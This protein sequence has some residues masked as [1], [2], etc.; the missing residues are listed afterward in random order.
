MAMEH[1]GTVI[2][3]DA[4][5]I[6]SD[7]PI[8]SAQPGPEDQDLVPHRLYGVLD[9]ADPCSAA[10]W[11]EMARAEIDRCWSEGRLPILVGGTGLYLKALI[12]GLAPVPPVD[13]AVRA[14]IRAMPPA[15]VRQA[16]EAED[17]ALAARLNVNDRQRNARALEVIRSTGKSLLHWQQQT[18][19][20]IGDR[21]E[22]AAWLVLPAREQL[23]RSCDLRFDR[24]IAAGALEEV[25]R[26]RKRQLSPELP[27]MKAL[28]VPP[29]IAHLEGLLTLDE[30]IFRSKLQT[31]QYAKRQRTWF[32]SGGQSRGWLSSA[33]SLEG[34]S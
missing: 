26:L 7:L 30:A 2:N 32:A 10:R 18:E 28:G 14:A 9:G 33:G 6:Y 1:G 22:L 16:L 4:S 20:G 21:V 5:Q 11:V 8:L 24:M 31:R 15:D 17:P 27:V 25:G 3:A 13:E 19:G 34:R 23:A 12:E 29:L